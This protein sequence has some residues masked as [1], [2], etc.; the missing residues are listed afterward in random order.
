M[1]R[2]A[3]GAFSGGLAAFLLLAT[4]AFAAETVISFDVDGQKVIGTLETPDGVSKPPVVL[5]FHGFSGSRDELP[6]NNTKE[7]VFSRSA[8]L[9]SEAGYASLRID[10]RGSGESGG[11]WADTT[12]SGQIK[13]GIAAVDWLKSNESVDAGRISILGWSQGGLVASHVAAAR[14][15]VKSVTLWAPV[16]APLYTYSAILG[17]DS[18]NK[19]LTSAPDVE[20]TSKLPW[21]VDTT[22]KASFF[23]EMATTSPI[24]AIAAYPGPLQVIVGTQDTTVSPQ[25]ASGQVFLNYHNG[26]ERLDIFE[27]DHVFSAFTGP[28]VIDQKMVP[29]TVEWL[30]AHNP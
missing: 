25:P 30:K 28:E 6:V 7:G 12:F 1:S 22:L 9:L 15:E 26:E 8:R 2:T 29:S 17:A 27:T 10:F 19:G 21:G 23:K 24:G 18:V 3:S 13:D 14:P 16:A 4:P 5:M 20:I 11:K